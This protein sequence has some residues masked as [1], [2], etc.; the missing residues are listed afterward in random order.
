M[1]CIRELPPS[2]DELYLEINGE[3]LAFDVDEGL[4][5]ICDIGIEIFKALRRLHIC[6]IVA[7]IPDPDGVL[8][9]CPEK[10]VR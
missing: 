6:D 4:D 2:L 5:P 10:A 1:A 8:A 3:G 9:P 7:W